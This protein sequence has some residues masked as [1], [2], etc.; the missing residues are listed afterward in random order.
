M[1][2]PPVA[3]KGWPSGMLPPIVVAS[4]GLER[5][6]LA[7]MTDVAKDEI[8]GATV[9]AL[10]G[11]SFAV[12]VVKCQPTAVVVASENPDAAAATR[13]RFSLCAIV[14]LPFLLPTSDL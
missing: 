14:H 1:R 5:E 13:G 7:L 8:P 2:R 11:P 6:S 12:E 10:S 3:P 9:V 4:K